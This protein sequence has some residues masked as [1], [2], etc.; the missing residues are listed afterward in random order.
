MY[1]SLGMQRK[2]V[3]TFPAES[4][5]VGLLIATQKRCKEQ[6]E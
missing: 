6:R 5:R 1:E 3:K 2:H 4:G